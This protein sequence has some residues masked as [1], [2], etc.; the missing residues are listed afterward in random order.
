M[1]GFPAIKMEHGKLNVGFRASLAGEILPSKKVAGDE[2]F[3][4]VPTIFGK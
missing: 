3:M 1:H 4:P 2:K